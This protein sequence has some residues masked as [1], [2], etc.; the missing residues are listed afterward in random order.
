M[1]LIGQPT[2]SRSML[3]FKLKLLKSRVLKPKSLIRQLR[4]DIKLTEEILRVLGCALSTAN[5]TYRHRMLDIGLY[6]IVHCS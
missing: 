5:S 1:A 4:L 6:E 2:S 3:N